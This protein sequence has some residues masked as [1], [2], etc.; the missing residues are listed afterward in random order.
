MTADIP[1]LADVLGARE[2]IAPYLRPTPLYGYPTLDALTG[3][4]LR[5]KHENHLPVGAFK[6]RGGINLISQLT[7]GERGRAVATAST[8]NHGQS[9][10]YAANLFGVR[11]IVFVPENANPVKI[12]SIRALGAEIVVHGR[13]FDDAR[14]YCEAQAAANGY[15]YIHSGNE[16]HLIAGVATY[17]L[18]I[19]Q[20][21][22]DTEVIVV[23]VGGGSGAAGAAIVAK[24]VRPAIEVIGVQSAAAPAAFRSWQEGALVTADMGTFA[25]GLATRTAFDLPQQILRALLDDFVLVPEDGLAESTRMMIEK[26]RNLVEPAGAAALAAVLADPARFAGRRVTI[27]CSGGNISPAQLAALWPAAAS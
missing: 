20:D 9:V 24:A 23:P 6:V 25:E 2:R 26:T 16:P 17:A 3:A 14:E 27:V 1:D 21:W 13:D 10:A 11:A 19:L 12:E 4:E 5:V 18:E 15:R 7:A 8:G 22:P